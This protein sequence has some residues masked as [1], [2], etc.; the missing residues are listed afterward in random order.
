MI[1]FFGALGHSHFLMLF[2][3]SALSRRKAGMPAPI[4]AINL[5]LWHGNLA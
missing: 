5:G 1:S 4:R 2:L 3:R